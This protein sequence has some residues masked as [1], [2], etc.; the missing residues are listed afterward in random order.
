MFQKLA[1]HQNDALDYERAK[2]LRQQPVLAERLLW[3]QLRLLA[4]AENLKFRRQHPLHPYI[5]DFVC[6]PAKLV[7]ELDGDSHDLRVDYDKNR[8]RSLGEMGY[9]VLRFA[10]AEVYRNLEGVGL[11]IAREVREMLMKTHVPL[12]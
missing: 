8:D 6:L 11:T 12:P 1:E 10:N 5:V 3:K 2:E 9:R 4:K 7:V